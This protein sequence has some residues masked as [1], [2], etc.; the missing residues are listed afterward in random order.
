MDLKNRSDGHLRSWGKICDL[1]DDYLQRVINGVGDNTIPQYEV[2][3]IKCK[4]F[5]KVLDKAPSFRGKTEASAYC[6]IKIIAQNETKDFFRKI[7]K[8]NLVDVDIDDLVICIVDK[9]LSPEENLINQEQIA[10]FYEKFEHF[11]KSL[12]ERQLEVLNLIYTGLKN[13]EIADK[14]GVKRSNITQ[15]RKKIMSKA[16]QYNFHE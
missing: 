5:D 14:L 16:R 8:D 6:W 11:F 3:Q 13:S 12:T 7:S 15:L 1:V 10:Q 9:E 4:T 2:N